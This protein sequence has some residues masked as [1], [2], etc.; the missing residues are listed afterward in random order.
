MSVASRA[1]HFVPT[2]A[3][4]SFHSAGNGPRRRRRKKEKKGGETQSECH[5]HCQAL[6]FSRRG[7]GKEKD[8]CERG[9]G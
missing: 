2:G 6:R 9:E 8:T 3:E 4:L 5:F 7:E 1:C